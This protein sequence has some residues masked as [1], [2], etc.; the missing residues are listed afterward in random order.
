MRIQLFALLGLILTMGVPAIGQGGREIPRT[1]DGRP[2]LTGNYDANT[3]TPVERV[4]KFSSR[5]ALTDQEAAELQRTQAARNEEGEKPSDPNRQAPKA[6]GFVGGYND[7]WMSRGMRVV[8]IDGEKRSSIVIDPPD[9]K[10]PTMTAEGKIRDDSFGGLAGRTDVLERRNEAPSSFDDPELRVNSERC[11]VGWGW[12]SGTPILP[13]Y[14]YN[15]LKQIVQTPTE[16]MILTEMIHDARIVRI[17]SKHL[18]SNVRKWLGD[19]V[20][21]WEGDTLVVETTNFTD[22]TRFRGASENL[23][24]TER[25]T[26]LDANTLLYHFTIEDPQT[27]GRPWTGEYTWVTS[28]ERMFEYACHENNY[29]LGGILRGAR[30]SESEAA[31]AKSEHK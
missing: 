18:P 21:H 11:L 30:V 28:N 6:G 3:I 17:G 8:T 24:V 7:F 25:F 10:I 2:D 22:K 4:E 31:A 5:R 14:L 16:V 23:K 26:R 29:A 27:W 19:S 15:N 9:G 12:T 13:N 1:P 20:G